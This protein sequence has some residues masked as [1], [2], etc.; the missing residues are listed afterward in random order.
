[1]K[2][3]LTI[4]LALAATAADA[5]YLVDQSLPRPT[6]TEATNVTT[7]GYTA[8]WRQ[9]TLEEYIDTKAIGFYVRTYA[10]HTAQADGERFYL[11]NTDFS[12]L[13][14]RGGS[15]E[16]P[17]PNATSSNKFVRGTIDDPCRPGTWTTVNTANAGGVL[18]L[19]GKY[20]MQ[21][22]NG[23]LVLNIT[24]LTNG[25]GDVH[26]KFRAK[27]DKDGRNMVV[28]LRKAN[29]EDADDVIEKY[30]LSNL[31]TEWRD[32]EFTLHGGQKES[33]ILIMGTDMGNLS[34]MYYFID[35]L[36]VWQE[37][38]EGETAQVLYND[39]FLK[40]DIEGTSLDMTVSGAYDGDAYAYTVSSYDFNSISPESNLVGVPPV[41]SAIHNASADGDA[42]APD[43]PVTV[44]SLGG[45][46]VAQ[47]T[48]AN[49]PTVP[50]GVYV[51]K[52]GSKTVKVMK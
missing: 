15:V 20:N 11:A 33:D 13:E 40:S 12:Y 46:I 34:K 22:A 31:T 47:G 52:T 2:L 16:A 3:L 14:Q 51:V 50:K 41:A 5:Q 44:Y 7:D 38:K 30:E 1:M 49:M 18:C 8:N 19:D 43:T 35:D 6:A 32:V 25:G 48:A 29:T 45:T 9:L 4:A 26:F 23:Q 10:T 28:Q 24:D 36:Q 42:T 27:S 17:V 37:L 39:A 21:F